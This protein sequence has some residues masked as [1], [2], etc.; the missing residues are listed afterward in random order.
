[1]PR[2]EL[3]PEVAASPREEAGFGRPEEVSEG[4]D[5][6]KVRGLAATLGSGATPPFATRGKRAAT[7]G[8][9]ASR[10]GV[11]SVPPR[12]DRSGSGE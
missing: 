11:G 3:R 1:M 8:E 5:R 7:V 4:P 10:D 2:P 9:A 12:T 6:A